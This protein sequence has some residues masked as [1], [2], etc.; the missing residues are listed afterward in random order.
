MHTFLNLACENIRFFSLFA[1]GNISRGGTSATQRSV[2]LICQRAPVKLKCFFWRLYS[3]ILTVLLEIL[4]AYMWSL[5]PFVFCLSFV[6]NSL[7]NCNDSVDQSALLTG[8]GT[9][10]T[11]S[12]WNFCRW[13]ADVPPRE[14]SLTAKSEEKRMFSQALLN[15]SLT[16]F[17]QISKFHFVKFWKTNSTMCKYRQRVFI[18]MVCRLES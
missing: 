2:L 16:N 5:W 9:D 11:S 8:F 10:F 18:W 12:V 1:T 3:T 13:V 7:N 6:N 17:N 15:L 4:R 14:T